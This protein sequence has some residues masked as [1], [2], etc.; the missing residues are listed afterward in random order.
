MVSLPAFCIL[1]VVFLCGN[2]AAEK[3]LA[4]VTVVSNM[5]LSDKPGSFAYPLYDSFRLLF[6]GKD[7]A[8]KL[9]C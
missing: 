6:Y 5:Y 7:A 9:A 4:Y 1:A 2:A 8:T 3:Q